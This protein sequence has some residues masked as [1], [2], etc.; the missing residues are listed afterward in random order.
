MV[1]LVPPS[2]CSHG[3]PFVRHTFP[4]CLEN[5][6]KPYEISNTEYT[7]FL[8]FFL[9]ALV[10]ICLASSATAQDYLQ[11]ANTTHRQH[12][13]LLHLGSRRD[14]DVTDFVVNRT[15]T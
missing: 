9:R 10:S 15:T 7:L 12:Y 8:S 3:I 11:P 4:R 14:S 6:T 1:F 5:K 2:T 13:R